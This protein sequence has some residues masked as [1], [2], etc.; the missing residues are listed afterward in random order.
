[1]P[2]E[3]LGATVRR[4]F[5]VAPSEPVAAHHERHGGVSATMAVLLLVQVMVDPTAAGWR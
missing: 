5:A 2:A 4:C 3:Q 1:V